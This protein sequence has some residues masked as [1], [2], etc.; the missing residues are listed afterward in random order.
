[1][2]H[3]PEEH[4]SSTDWKTILLDEV[5]WLLRTLGIVSLSLAIGRVVTYVTRCGGIDAN[6]LQGTWQHQVDE[7]LRKRE[8]Q[9]RRADYDDEEEP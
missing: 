7:A 6:I 8:Q 1:M 3:E 9:T 4:S 5:L 2:D